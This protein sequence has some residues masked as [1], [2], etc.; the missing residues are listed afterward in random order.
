[1]AGKHTAAEDNV[2]CKP[3][4]P[5][6]FDAFSKAWKS[7]GFSESVMQRNL[8]CVTA[9]NVGT[10]T[11]SFPEQETCFFLKTLLDL[12]NH[13]KA[14]DDLYTDTICRA[15]EKLIGK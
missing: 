7:G 3:S 10:G 8:D 14:T 11:L 4:S 15:L 13:S 5:A 6:S 2:V 12:H 1:M 9:G